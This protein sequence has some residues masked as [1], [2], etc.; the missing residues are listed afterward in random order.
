[1]SG[2]GRDEYDQRGGGYGGQQDENY[3]Q[4]QGGGGRQQQG[5]YGDDQG[6]GGYV[7]HSRFEIYHTLDFYSTLIRSTV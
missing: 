4:Q 6:Y 1:M 7:M 5:G 3:R 2:Y